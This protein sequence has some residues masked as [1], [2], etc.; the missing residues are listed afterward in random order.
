MEAFEEKVNSQ[1]TRLQTQNERLRDAAFHRLEEKVSQTE[2]SQPKV[3]RRLA[4]LTGNVRGLSDELHSQIRRIDELDHKIWDWT[5]GFDEGFGSKILELQQASEQLVGSQRI[6]SRQLEDFQR[7]GYDGRLQALDCKVQHLEAALAQACS[8]HEDASQHLM[9]LQESHSRHAEDLSRLELLQPAPVDVTGPLES[10]VR[11][12][13]RVSERIVQ[14]SLELGQRLEQAEERLG[15]LRQRHEDGQHREELQKSRQMRDEA[16]QALASMRQ[17]LET[18]ESWREKCLEEP[19]AR[20]QAYQSSPRLDSMQVSFTPVAELVAHESLQ[21]IDELESKVVTLE[22]HLSSRLELDM[23]LEPRVGEMLQTLHDLVPKI[24][25]LDCDVRNLKTGQLDH[26]NTH[27]ETKEQLAH[28]KTDV[29]LRHAR[30]PEMNAL[31][32]EF[33]ACLAQVEDKVRP[34]QEQVS[35]LQQEVQ[36]ASKSFQ[37]QNGADQPSGREEDSKRAAKTAAKALALDEE[38]LAQLLA[39]VRSDEEAGYQ[40]QQRLLRQVSQLCDRF[41]DFDGIVARLMEERAGVPPLCLDQIQSALRRVECS[42]TETEEL[43][44]KMRALPLD[45]KSFQDVAPVEVTPRES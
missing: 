7:R 15:V 4:E 34:V 25:A 14:D 2:G 32:A 30:I 1:V 20:S 38:E 41:G 13:A 40:S 45:H 31:R 35:R 21:R 26:D 42:V 33:S 19:D 17:R 37:S 43:Q 39:D 6:A 44:R 12:L 24:V 18:L 5:Q 16:L 22:S 29:E 10:R 23:N 9:T 8:A 28:L 36:L 11:E 27:A 3:E